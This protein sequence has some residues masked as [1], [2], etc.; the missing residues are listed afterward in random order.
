MYTH[1][2][3]QETFMPTY[4]ITSPQGT[5][6]KEQKR[7]IARN[8]TRVHSEVTGA[9][10]FF[11]QVVFVETAEESWF[12]GGAPEAATPI[13]LHGQIRSGR[14]AEIKAKLLDLLVGVVAEGSSIPKRQI[15]GYLHELPPSHMVEYGRV[16]P[17]PGQEARW[18]ASL[19]VEERETMERMGR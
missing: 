16:L 14:S 5:L 19:P 4:T 2:A 18:L 11:A 10:T 6:G 8:V 13:F 9:N 1:K 17:E 12:Q 7:Q 15:W 3:R